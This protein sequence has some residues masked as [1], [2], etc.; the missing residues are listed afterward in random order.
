M[1]HDVLLTAGATRDLERL[2]EYIR[3]T[4]S[5]AGANRVLDKLVAAAASLE[6]LP[7]RGSHPRELAALGI[8]EYRQIYFKPYRVIYRVIGTQVVIHVIADGRR[9]FRTLLEERLLNP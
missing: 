4:D 2:H 8:H 3:R 1:R 6:T 5:L 9:D 7:K